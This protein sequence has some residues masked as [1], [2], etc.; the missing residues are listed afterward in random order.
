MKR[1]SIIAILSVIVVAEAFMLYRQNDSYRQ[2]SDYRHQELDSMIVEAEGLI[3]WADVKFNELELTRDS[4]HAE[5]DSLLNIRLE[6]DSARKIV[7]EKSY[8]KHNDINNANLD[9][10]SKFMSRYI[11]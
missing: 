6:L 7:K 11:E 10:L 9:E 2:L 1:S 8:E 5:R 3:E 4:L